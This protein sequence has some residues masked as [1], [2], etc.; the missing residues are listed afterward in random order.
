MRDATG[1]PA[2][3]EL[4]KAQRAGWRTGAAAVV[5]PARCRHR[6]GA[7]LAS[8]FSSRYL[9]GGYYWAIAGAALAVACLM[10]WGFEPGHRHEDPARLR[11]ASATARAVPR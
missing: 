5:V 3:L 2:A 9:P 11:G 1:D 10:Q 8:P 6:V 4:L 7:D